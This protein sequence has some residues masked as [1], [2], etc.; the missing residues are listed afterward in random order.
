MSEVKLGDVKVDDVYCT[1][2]KDHTGIVVKVTP[3]P[4]AADKPKVIIRHDSS[5]QGKVAENEFA[6]YFK[7]KGTFHR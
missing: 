1:P 2:G 4:K 7:G 3:D 6:T 5:A